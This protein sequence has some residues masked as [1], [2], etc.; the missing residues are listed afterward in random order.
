MES[1]R[2][3][4]D[5]DA[6]F[7]ID[8]RYRYRL[9]RAWAVGPIALF[10]MLNPSTANAEKDDPTIC[11]CIKLARSWG[12]GALDVVN[13]CALISPHPR[14]LFTTRDPVGPNTRPICRQRS[15]GATGPCSACSP[16]AP[17]SSAWGRP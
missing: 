2:D 12:S 17:A 1:P 3:G 13:L 9:T 16:R 10:V 7:S 5:R 14:A 15:A 6:E 11:K 4:I 8:L